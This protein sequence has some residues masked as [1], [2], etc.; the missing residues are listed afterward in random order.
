MRFQKLLPP[1]HPV[2]VSL[3]TF[4]TG[5]VSQADKPGASFQVPVGHSVALLSPVVLTK[6][7]AGALLQTEL[8]VVAANVPTMQIEHTAASEAPSASLAVP[9]GHGLQEDEPV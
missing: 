4:P 6:E 2:N 1:V 8:P 5:H 7:P 9:M 3:D